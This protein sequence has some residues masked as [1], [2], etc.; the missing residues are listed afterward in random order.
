MPKQFR[1]AVYASRAELISECE[2]LAPET[3]VFA[4]EVV[5]IT[6]EARAFVL[7]GRVLDASTYEGMANAKDALNFVGALA[8]EMSLPPVVVVDVG[9]V[10]DLGWLVIEFNAAWGAGLNGCDPDMVLPAIVAAS[11][12][13]R[14]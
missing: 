8:R 13:D 6:A 7:G 3:P 2:G 1:G 12:P 5:L 10:N 4:S 14:S 11:E 9:L